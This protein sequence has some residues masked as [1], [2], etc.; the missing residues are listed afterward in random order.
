MATAP[1]DRRLPVTV[2]SGF[3]G[4]GKTTLLNHL[5]HNREGRRIAVIVNDMSEVNVDAALVERGDAQLDRVEERL[6]EMSNGCICCTLRE[7]LLVEVTRLA[8]EGRFDHLVIESTGISEPLPVAET[9]T[10]EGE[11]GTSLSDVARLDSMV[12]VVDAARFVD[13][14]GSVDDITA[15]GESLGEDD[16]RTVA[17]LLVDQVEFADLIVLNKTDLVDGARLKRTESTVR[18]LNRGATIVHAEH[19]RVPLDQLLDTG[20]FDFDR[21]S[22]HPGWLQVLRGEEQPETE[23]Y[24]IGSLVYRQRRPFHP[25][26]LWAAVHEPWPGV[27]RSKGFFW[28]ASRPAVVG[29]WSTAGPIINLGAIGTWWATVPEREWP[30]DPELR[31]QLREG[32]HPRFGDRRQELVLIGHDLDRDALVARLDAAL[33]TDEE[34]AA[35]PAALLALPD[36]WP[37]WGS[38]ELHRHGRHGHDD[39]PLAA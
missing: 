28:I 13:D 38:D 6:V 18:T 32:W 16:E 3:L 26:R 29:E 21:A 14:L 22:E 17:D 34:L 15:R 35:G 30:Q 33:V 11:D 12:T 2:L 1:T 31:A 7:D 36:P 25:E 5:L 9:F 37:R 20:R 39:A 10:F 27:I 23:E 4:A 24:G 19:G 8:R